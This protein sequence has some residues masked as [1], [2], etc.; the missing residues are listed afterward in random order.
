[1]LRDQPR[2]GTGDRSRGA[3]DVQNRAHLML[4]LTQ[5]IEP[6]RLRF[7]LAQNEKHRSV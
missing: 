7:D 3:M 4:I 1:M 6:D 5:N 2:A